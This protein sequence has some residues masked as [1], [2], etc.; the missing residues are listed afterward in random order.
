[1]TKSSQQGTPSSPLK[2]FFSESALSSCLL[3]SWSFP[4]ERRLT[5]AWDSRFFSWLHSRSSSDC[6]TFGLNL[7]A[8]VLLFH[9]HKG[10]V[11]VNL[12]LSWMKG[13]QMWR[14][15]QCWW[16]GSAA[17]AWMPPWGRYWA[18]TLQ[19]SAAAGAVDPAWSLSRTAGTEHWAGHWR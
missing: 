6:T 15:T 18:G 8:Y 13:V 4:D 19:I 1:M 5:P 14:F 17:G 2:S 11:S 9:R 10:I 3:L 12:S 7:S 16:P